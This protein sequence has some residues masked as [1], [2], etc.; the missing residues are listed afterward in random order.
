MPDDVASGGSR[1]GIAPR[2]DRPGGDDVR[3]ALKDAI[4]TLGTGIFRQPEILVRDLLR[5]CPTAGDDIAQLMMALD[6]QV[7][8]ALMS[9]ENDADLQLLAARLER[10]LV[11]RRALDPAAATWTVRAWNDALRWRAFTPSLPDV[12]STPAPRTDAMPRPRSEAAPSTTTSPVCRARPWPWA[13]IATTAA[14]LGLLVFAIR[15]ELAPPVAPIR[16]GLE[17]DRAALETRP[18]SPAAHLPTPPSV[19]DVASSEALVGD[20]RAREIFVTLD[21]GDG[22]GD[23]R[24]IEARLV[25]GDTPTDALRTLTSVPADRPAN[26]R[27]PVGGIGLRT[28]RDATVLYEFVAIARDGTRSAPFAKTFRIAAVP[29]RAPTIVDVAVP[30]DVFAGRRF[31]L[32][33]DYR[34]GERQLAAVERRVLEPSGESIVAT[35]PVDGIVAGPLRLS[36]DAG[37]LPGALAIDVALIDRDGG[38]SEARHLDLDVV[39][40]AAVVAPRAAANSAAAKGAANGAV[41][42]CRPDT[43]GVV[44]ASRAA[45]RPT[46]RSVAQVTQALGLPPA[47]TERAR[48]YQVTVRLD[49]RTTRVVTRT[50][51]LPVGSRVRLAGNTITLLALRRR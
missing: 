47:E 49:N 36:V 48:R 17:P 18:A 43:C 33:I 22:R 2:G 41:A 31:D 24:A 45:D 21:G 37:R 39:A 44:V 9:V 7:P 14:M 15:W 29:T 16:P 35:T 11:A 4:E 38:R 27:V 12:P 25:G 34:D 1:P 40:P 3:G 10:R 30:P 20:G 32:T 42:A 5:R 19:A 51:G 6:E 46:E 8:Q 50:A 26:G 23:V 13:R 28:T